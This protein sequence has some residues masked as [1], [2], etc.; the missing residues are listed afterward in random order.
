VIE[1]YRFLADCRV[2]FV[3]SETERR[4]DTTVV[5]ETGPSGIVTPYRAGNGSHI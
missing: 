2:G 3:L 5:P 4:F 1:F